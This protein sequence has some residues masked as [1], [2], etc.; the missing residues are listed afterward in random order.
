MKKRSA[1]NGASGPGQIEPVVGA[2][3]A[4]PGHG[5]PARVDTQQPHS[6]GVKQWYDGVLA[7]SSVRRRYVEVDGGQVHLLE[8]GAGTP[9]VLLHGSGVAAGFFLPLVDQL[10]G[11]RV[12][13]PDLP[14]SGLSDPI[15]LPPDRFHE[16]AAAWLDHLLDALELDATALLGHSAGG[17]WALRY[18]LAHPDRITRLVLI[19]PPTLPGTRCPLPYRLLGTPGVG[20][21]LSRVP[22]SHSSVLRLAGFMGERETL[23]ARPELVDLFMVA[24]RDPVAA[25]A[26]RAEVRVLISPFAVLSH[27]GWRRATR[28]RRDE[29]RRVATPTLLLWGEREPLGSVA[30]ARAVTELIPDARLTV[31]PGGHGPWLG[32]PE[33]TATTVADFVR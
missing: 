30:V 7:G 23:A 27:S 3:D 31:L 18:A 26:L 12:I 17:V 19:G 25:S 6:L 32:W 2:G 21:L 20:S 22:P 4:G 11:V 13:A 8:K 33:Q 28:V 29:L 24:G 9:L 15:D 1:M 5:R 10:D 14:G 16:C